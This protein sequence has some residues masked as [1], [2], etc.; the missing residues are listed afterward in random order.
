MVQA[1]RYVMDDAEKAAELAEAG[2]AT[3]ITEAAYLS[4]SDEE[5]KPFAKRSVSVHRV[6]VE[7]STIR[8]SWSDA[9]G[10]HPDRDALCLV[11]GQLRSPSS[12]S[13]MHKLATLTAEHL[14]RLCMQALDSTNEPSSADPLTIGRMEG[15]LLRGGLDGAG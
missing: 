12:V 14:G 4:L 9:A 5:R 7:G 10:S 1:T 13:E 15:M 8:L 3:S 6:L 11:R 2:K